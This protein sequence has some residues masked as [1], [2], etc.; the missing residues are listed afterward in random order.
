MKDKNLKPTDTR[1]RGLH[2]VTPADTPKP[3]ARESGAPQP[4][5][6]QPDQSEARQFAEGI[7]QYQ[8]L[9][10]EFEGEVLSRMPDLDHV[11][12]LIRD[13]AVLR[14]QLLTYAERGRA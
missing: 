10:D 4:E 11:T 5:S 9:Q 7:L 6:P 3:A 12:Q 8:T 2:L 14:K 13:L 1:R